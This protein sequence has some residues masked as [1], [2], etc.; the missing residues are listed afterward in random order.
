MDWLHELAHLIQMANIFQDIFHLPPRKP[1]KLVAGFCLSLEA[2]EPWDPLQIS[3]QDCKSKNLEV[4]GGDWYTIQNLKARQAEVLGSKAGGSKWM[5]HPR[6]R[7]I[8]FIPPWGLYPG[9]QV[10]TTISFTVKSLS[11]SLIIPMFTSYGHTWCPRIPVG[12]TCHPFLVLTLPSACS[13]PL[14]Y[15]YMTYIHTYS[16]SLFQDLR[17]TCFL[18]LFKAPI[19]PSSFPCLFTH[20]LYYS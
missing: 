16:K 13:F 3:G 7:R 5:I 4:N 9:P 6:E 10:Q 1:R 11:S 18:Y 12:K 8:N 2:W 15:I 17:K 19:W 14:A 20:L